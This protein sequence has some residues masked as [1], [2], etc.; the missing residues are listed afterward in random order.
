MT[1]ADLYARYRAGLAVLA[2]AIRDE[3]VD[4]LAQ[5]DDVAVTGELMSDAQMADALSLPWNSHPAEVEDQL[6]FSVAGPTI[7]LARLLG[8]VT[9]N[10]RV[11]ELTDRP[12][13]S[14]EGR[15]VSVTCLIPT[16]L[17][18]TRWQ[19]VDDGPIAFTI[20]LAAND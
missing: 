8:P 19:D 12:S 13:Q 2:A 1:G 5:V 9:T 17:A 16:H 18:P 6:R 10:F 3:L 7:P 20:E 4:I 14:G 11:L 15:R